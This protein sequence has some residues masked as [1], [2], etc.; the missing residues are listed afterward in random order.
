MG[1]LVI[2]SIIAERAKKSLPGGWSFFPQGNV[3][4][5]GKARKSAA[6]AR[7][8]EKRRTHVPAAGHEGSLVIGAGVAAAATLAIE[9]YPAL[10]TNSAKG[11][12]PSVA[13]LTFASKFMA[14]MPAC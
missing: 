5:Q 2:T 1:R 7:P 10:L 13:S 11:G 14:G 9:T 6:A 8:S 4:W 3:L 12:R